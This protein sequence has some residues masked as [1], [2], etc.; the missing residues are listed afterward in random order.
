MV[1]L[2]A[3]ST[4]HLLFSL[5]VAG[6]FAVLTHLFLDRFLK[7]ARDLR[8]PSGCCAENWEQLG[9]GFYVSPALFLTY[10]WSACWPAVDVVAVAPWSMLFYQCILAHFS[11][12]KSCH[13]WTK[14]WYCYLKCC[15]HCLGVLFAWGIWFMTRRSICS[16]DRSDY[17]SLKKASIYI[18]FNIWDQIK[19]QKKYCW[20]RKAIHANKRRIRWAEWKNEYW[21][22]SE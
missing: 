14:H 12:K 6:C 1:K 13:H 20:E 3:F 16:F 22:S 11:F 17:F 2:W 21:V 4:E 9:V 8:E 10:C 18:V 15:W 5:S 7:F 19:R